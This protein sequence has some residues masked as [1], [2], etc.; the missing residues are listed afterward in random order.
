MK[1][2]FFYHHTHLVS[3][4]L[5]EIWMI[6]YISELHNSIMNRASLI[7]EQHDNGI[8]ASNTM[9]TR[10]LMN[11]IT[12]KD[13]DKPLNSQSTQDCPPLASLIVFDTQKLHT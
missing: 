7:I 4:Q 11:M 6:T 2:I 3:M 8:D 5:A 1:S 13:K 12:F 10:H 9:N